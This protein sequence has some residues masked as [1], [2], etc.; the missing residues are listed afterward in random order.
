MG[1]RWG[2]QRRVGRDVWAS[3]PGH[4]SRRLIQPAGAS[5]V[6]LPHNLPT[7]AVAGAAAGMM[8]GAAVR[9]AAAAA[10]GARAGEAAGAVPGGAMA[11]V[12]GIGSIVWQ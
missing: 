8:A 6:A 11:G 10:A 7:G 5:S 12:T 2:F 4:R 3:H 1:G 9:V